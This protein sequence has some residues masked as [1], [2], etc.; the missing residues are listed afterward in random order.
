MRKVVCLVG[1]VAVMGGCSSAAQP[2]GTG[3]T[4]S[5]IAQDCNGNDDGLRSTAAQ[6][7]ALNAAPIVIGHEGA[8]ENFAQWPNDV[9]VDPTK[10]IND[11]VDSLRLAYQQGASLA[12]IDAEMTKDGQI[13]AF[14][15]FDFLPDYTCINTYTLRDLQTKVPY[16]ATLDE[17]LRAARQVNHTSRS[18]SGLLMIELKTPS[19]LCDPGDV[20]EA[21]F[22]KAVVDTVHHNVMDDA[23]MFD[24][25]SPNLVALAKQYAPNV[26]REL[27]LDLLQLLTPAQVEAQGY[28]VTEITKAFNPYGLQWAEVGPAGGPAIYRL[29][30][31]TGVPQFFGTA[32][33]AGASIID[34]ESDF[35]GV[36][37]AAGVAQ[38]VGTAHALGMKAYADPAKTESDFAS[39]AAL[40]FDGAYCDDIPDSL[41]LQPKL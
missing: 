30:G 32:V 20:E 39:F 28:A 25:F 9:G 26:P 11:T 5:A 7:L 3:S 40:G 17:L 12:E 38:F 6:F 36:A 31:Y 23:V 21:P 10:P 29:P 22:V 14:H 15:D 8:G 27:D 4:S 19:P 35:I 1:I 41:T 16:I 2:E 24:G 18:M 33:A 37:G 13:V 34:G